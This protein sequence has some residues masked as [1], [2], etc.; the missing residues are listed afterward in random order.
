MAIN[1]I[2]PVRSC[3]HLWPILDI[4]QRKEVVSDCLKCLAAHKDNFD[5]IAV[6]GYSMSLIGS[7]IAHKMNKGLI[8]VR[9]DE[10][11]RASNFEVEGTVCDR[12]IIIDDLICSGETLRR[13]TNKISELH[14]SPAKLYGVYLY[15]INHSSVRTVGSVNDIY[16]TLL[17]NT[18][19]QIR[20]QLIGSQSRPE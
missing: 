10:D 17:L 9:K 16:E 7:I 6:S 15:K 2:I 5:A 1:K 12:Y 8:I 18:P 14:H 20:K 13:I 11:E 4:K 3:S 19:E